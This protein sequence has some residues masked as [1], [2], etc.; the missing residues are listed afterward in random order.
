MI[1]SHNAS[2]L[3]SAMQLIEMTLTLSFSAKTS[4]IMA[5]TNAV[6]PV[7]GAPDINMLV[8]W[9]SWSMDVPSINGVKNLSREVRSSSRP[10]IEEE[11]LLQVERSKART[12]A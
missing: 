8:V 11:V 9:V 2:T 5:F 4:Q 7:P 3:F 12:R 6:F 10:A 1:R